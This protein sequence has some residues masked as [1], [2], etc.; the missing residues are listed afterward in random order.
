[1]DAEKVEVIFNDA[2][3]LPADGRA[4]FLSEA[5]GGDRELREEVESLLAS[6]DE[7]FLEDDVSVK[8]LELVRGGLLPGDVIGGRYEIVEIA[9][10]STPAAARYTAC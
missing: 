2:L 4:S 9:V 10:V 3:R 8:V 5:C 1:M 6:H 7:N